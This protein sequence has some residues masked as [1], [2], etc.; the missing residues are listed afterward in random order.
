MWLKELQLSTLTMVKGETD[1]RG[2]RLPS[3][4]QFALW[5]IVNVKDMNVISSR[6]R[7]VPINR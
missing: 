6:L 5:L 1:L 4:Q 3:P 7:P 2:K